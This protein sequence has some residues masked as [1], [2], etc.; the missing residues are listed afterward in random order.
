MSLRELREAM[1]QVLTEQVEVGDVS[2]DEII[3]IVRNRFPSLISPSRSELENIAMKRILNDLSSRQSK[4]PKLSA[5]QDLF[6]EL[7]SLPVLFSLKDEDGLLKKRKFERVKLSV[8]ISA[9]EKEKDTPNS[10]SRKQVA[11]ALKNIANKVGSSDI[12]YESAI[13][14]LNK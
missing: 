2:N 13:L 14:Q 9:Y 8:L 7:S 10:K 11:Q 6:G 3:R 5:Q 12:T 1:K 4:L